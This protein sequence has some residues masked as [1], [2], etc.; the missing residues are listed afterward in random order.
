MSQECGEIPDLLRRWGKGEGQLCPLSP[1]IQTHLAIHT[2]KFET[3]LTLSSLP[4]DS[5]IELSPCQQLHRALLPSVTFR[6]SSHNGMSP[7]IIFRSLPSSPQLSHPDSHFPP[8]QLPEYS[9][10]AQNPSTAVLVS[11]KI[12]RRIPPPI[13]PC[14]NHVKDRSSFT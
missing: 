6:D 12:T 8:D 5:F 13:S 4:L 14:A 3:H 11:F 9:C 2:W 1:S 7:L 10:L